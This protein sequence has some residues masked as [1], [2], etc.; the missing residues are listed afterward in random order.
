MLERKTCRGAESA[1]QRTGFRVGCSLKT[2]LRSAADPARRVPAGA[3]FV[4][5]GAQAAP[6]YWLES[7]WA[8]LFKTLQDGRDQI[9]DIHLAGDLVQPLA[10]DGLTASGG[11]QALTPCVV[12]AI[13]ASRWERLRAGCKPV[14]DACDVQAAAVSARRGERMLRLGRGSAAMRLAYLLLELHLRLGAGAAA[15]PRA[16]HLPMTQRQIGDAAGLCS[17]HVSRVFS[18]FNR[19]GVMTTRDHTDV[20]LRDIGRLC[21]HAGVEIAALRRAI[22]LPQ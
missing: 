21:A 9:I 8:V 16:F 5:E 18:Q 20:E 2:C 4:H 22:I 17:V 7:G 15:P 3:H 11:L 1:A 10:A 19:D 14:R 6:C 13:H 12:S